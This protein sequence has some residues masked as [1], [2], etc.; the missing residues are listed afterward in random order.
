MFESALCDSLFNPF[1]N[2]RINNFLHVLFGQGFNRYSLYVLYIAVTFD[3]SIK[4]LFMERSSSGIALL[5]YRFA[6]CSELLLASNSENFFRLLKGIVICAVD[7]KN[8]IG[9]TFDIFG[10]CRPRFFKTRFRTPLRCCK[11]PYC[12]RTRP[13]VGIPYVLYRLLQL[14]QWHDGNG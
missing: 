4:C 10:K 14:R 13:I 1:F 12:E 6:V 5:I 3:G 2:R 8:G 11:Y 7:Y 9:D